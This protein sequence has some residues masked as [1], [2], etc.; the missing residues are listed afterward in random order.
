MENEGYVT[1][2]EPAC[3]TTDLTCTAGDMI[4]WCRLLGAGVWCEDVTELSEWLNAD[5]QLVL[6]S[7]EAL[8]LEQTDALGEVFRLRELAA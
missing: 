5:L 3:N 2:S 8:T 6:D 1:S 7:I 4:P